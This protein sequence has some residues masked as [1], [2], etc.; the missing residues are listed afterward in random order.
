[1]AEST[2][3]YIHIPDS[4]SGPIPTMQL[5]FYLF[6]D[7]INILYISYCIYFI[8]S[9]CLN[10]LSVGNVFI[11]ACCKPTSIM[12]PPDWPTWVPSFY[13]RFALCLA[14]H[15]MQIWL[16]LWTHVSYPLHVCQPC[17]L[18]QKVRNLII[19]V[20]LLSSFASFWGYTI[21]A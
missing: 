21:N 6:A 17:L 18:K 15:Q 1:M 14:F 9:A 8:N 19:Q 10:F 4:Q 7:I 2:F 3:Q 16:L 13:F 5:G 12:E 20:R 11:K